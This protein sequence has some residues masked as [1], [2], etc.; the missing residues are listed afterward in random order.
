MDIQGVP[1]NLIDPDGKIVTRELI[2]FL[3]ALRQ[4]AVNTTG[5]GTTAQ[6]PNDPKLG[7]LYFDSTLAKEIVCTTERVGG[8]A[9]VWTLV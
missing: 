6:R 2:G 1:Q 5:Y 4:V 9:A 8:V 7:Q 3:N